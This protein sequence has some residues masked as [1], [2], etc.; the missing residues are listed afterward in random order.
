M[1]LVCDCAGAAALV[2]VLNTL[3][4]I[5]FRR[6]KEAHWTERARVLFPVRIAA[7]LAIWLVPANLV[8]A[9]QL[10]WPGRV[11]HWG[12]AGPVAWLGAVAGAYPFDREIMP[13]LTPRAWPHQVLASWLIRFA[14]WMV[15]GAMILMM[16]NELD[17]RGWLLAALFAGLF[18]AWCW[19]GLLWV[20]RQLRL[21]RPR[22]ERLRSIV[23]DVAGRMG[24]PVRGVWLLEYAGSFAFA[25]PYTGDLAFSGRLLARCP[26]EEVAA[27]CAHELGHLAESKL[28]IG[29]R[30]FLNLAWLLPWLFLKPACHAFD[31]GGIVV[32]A[33]GSF[34]TMF[35]IRWF[36]RR[37]EEK[38]DRAAH[39]NEG[40]AG[41]FARA[42]A[43][44]YEDNLVPAVLPRRRR[45]HPDLYDRLLA[46]GV[47]PDFP[48]PAAPSSFAV[49]S[50]LLF[51]LLGILIGITLARV[52]P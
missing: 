30:V 32:I 39:A 25:L 27:I 50:V 42:L 5:P 7:R 37:L 21:L 44:L 43:R 11:P 35:G 13:W 8:L 20:G 45:M 51:V 12:L 24:V 41:T 47:Q 31:L 52:F 40:E 46:A 9:Q 2:W 17:W 48:K 4:L 49:H 38:A 1:I 22:P 33:A 29:T 16:P 19:G 28:T 15:L 34:F 6:A 26:D 14:V 3:A 23:V 36:S 18:V 10:I